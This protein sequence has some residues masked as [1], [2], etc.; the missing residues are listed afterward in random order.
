[1][2]FTTATEWTT[3]SNVSVCMAM[4]GTPYLVS[5]V[6]ACAA[7]AGAQVLQWPTPRMAACPLARISSHVVGS[8]SR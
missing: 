4:V 3:R 5:S 1:M 6:M 8:S 7:T 2:P